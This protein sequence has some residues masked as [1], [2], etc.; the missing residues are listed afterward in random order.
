MGLVGVLS[1]T[2]IGGEEIGKEFAQDVVER[3]SAS[4]LAVRSLSAL[5][6][7]SLLAPEPGNPLAS[8][9]ILRP[10]PANLNSAVSPNLAILN[11]SLISVA[12]RRLDV[13]YLNLSL[14]LERIFDRDSYGF[15]QLSLETLWSLTG[16]LAQERGLLGISAKNSANSPGKEDPAIAAQ[17]E[18]DTDTFQAQSI[19][20]KSAQNQFIELVNLFNLRKLD[21]F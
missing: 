14:N 19:Q 21:F 3:I 2:P 4:C 11:Q 16:I 6:L 10:R 5:L 12:K 13:Q 15:G 18:T 20:S 9:F 8:R 1:A 17:A 7:Q